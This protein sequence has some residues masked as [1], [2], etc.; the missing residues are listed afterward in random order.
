MASDWKYMFGAV[1]TARGLA[2]TSRPFFD[3]AISTLG[4]GEEVIVTVER[5]QEKRTNPQ[6]RMAWGTVYS[7]LLDGLA[8]EVGY[9]RHDKDAKDKLHEGLTG[10]YGGLVVDPVTGFE[11]RK[12]RTSRAT[13]QEFSDYIEWVARFAA[14]EHGVVIVLPGE[15]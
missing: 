8:A 6:N 15:L 13:K 14:Q 12:F 10:K 11:V 7:Q 4:D 5:K 9:D 3:R 2:F 1:K